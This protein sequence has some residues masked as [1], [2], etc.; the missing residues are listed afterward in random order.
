MLDERKKQGM[1]VGVVALAAIFI[2]L[3]FTRTYI[4]FDKNEPLKVTFVNEGEIYN[5]D[6]S[7]SSDTYKKIEDIIEEKFY[8][9]AGKT[10]S[11]YDDLSYIT[12]YFKSDGKQSEIKIVSDGRVYL[13][14]DHIQFKFDTRSEGIYEDLE[15]IISKL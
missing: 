12:I 2:V 13:N 4:G 9:P 15:N 7:Y 1:I 14:D 10:S 5:Y 8:L 6:I 3:Y 11:P